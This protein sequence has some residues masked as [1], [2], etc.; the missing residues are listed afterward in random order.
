MI[1]AS[2]VKGFEKGR[3]ISPLVWS[4]IENRKKLTEELGV[5][6]VSSFIV[7]TD[8]GY[9]VIVFGE[10]VYLMSK[11]DLKININD[12]LPSWKQLLK[13]FDKSTDKK[14]DID[15]KKVDLEEEFKQLRHEDDEKADGFPIFPKLIKHLSKKKKKK[16]KK[17]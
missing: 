6:S 7:E 17:K 16:K 14:V 15:F 12:V 10:Y 11:L 13:I 9:I 8:Q 3:L 2:R 1:L 4:V 5:D